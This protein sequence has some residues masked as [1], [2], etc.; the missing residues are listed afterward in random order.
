MS[1][2]IP[3]RLGLNLF[4]HHFWYSD[5]YY[6]MY[7]QQDVLMH[8]LLETYL[9]YGSSVQTTLFWNPYWF[10]T[11]QYRKSALFLKYYRWATIQN[12]VFYTYTNYRFRLTGEHL[13]R[14]RFSL[15]RFNSWI[16]LNFF[17]FQP[18]K[19]Q[20]RRALI[21]DSHN[22][23]NIKS[24]KTHKDNHVV[25]LKSLLYYTSSKSQ[26]PNLRYHF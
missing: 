5:F 4:W 12:K 9:T 8:L 20:K 17:W 15:L 16:V 21:P 24:I 2:P 6:A 3:N 11:T 7:L 26:I 18:N 1:N 23:L 13:M 19:S 10:K 14:A 25:R 22:L